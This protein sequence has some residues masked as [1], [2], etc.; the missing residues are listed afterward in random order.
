MLDM[1]G[2]DEPALQREWLDKRGFNYYLRGGKWPVV[3]RDTV[4][5]RD[6]EKRPQRP[7]QQRSCN[8]VR[9]ADGGQSAGHLQLAAAMATALSKS[10]LWL[11]AV[12]SLPYPFQKRLVTWCLD[13][14]TQTGRLTG[15]DMLLAADKFAQ[16]FVGWKHASASSPSDEV[17]AG[18][19]SSLNDCLADA[20][21][22]LGQW[23]A[24]AGYTWQGLGY[25]PTPLSAREL[26]EAAAKEREENRQLAAALAEYAPEP[27]RMLPKQELLA[28]ELFTK[29]AANDEKC[30]EWEHAGGDSRESQSASAVPGQ[31]SEPAAPVKRALQAQ[32]DEYHRA[33]EFAIRNRRYA[34]WKHSRSP[35][36]SKPGPLHDRGDDS[37]GGRQ[38][39]AGLASGD[40][41]LSWV[42]EK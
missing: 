20:S 21:T 22:H 35:S 33:I 19:A 23:F 8:L 5:P 4:P 18:R 12:D 37:V 38:L 34:G 7:G 29:P 10:P 16:Q 36:I 27:E 13:A 42:I 3:M 11:Q 24:N 41:V 14:M 6:W 28:A 15:A 32:Q 17:R 40:A 25:M 39:S 31:Q 9:G 26:Q 1:T 2:T 30:S